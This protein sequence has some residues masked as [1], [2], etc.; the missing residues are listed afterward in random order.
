MRVKA[1]YVLRSAETALTRSL[2]VSHGLSE[3]T[4]LSGS[5]LSSMPVCTS[6]RLQSRPDE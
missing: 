2:G 4:H 3:P 6:L 5:A 1:D